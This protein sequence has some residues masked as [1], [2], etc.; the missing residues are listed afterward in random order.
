[1]TAIYKTHG[2]IQVPRS[3]FAL[4]VAKQRFGQDGDR[5]ND[6]GKLMLARFE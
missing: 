5:D 4:F 6:D 1:M 3:E 2:C